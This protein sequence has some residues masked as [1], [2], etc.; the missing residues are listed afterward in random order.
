MNQLALLFFRIRGAMKR[1]WWMPCLMAVLICSLSLSATEGEPSYTEPFRPQY[2]FTP[3]KNWMNDP[4]GLVFYEGEYH[5]FF[6]YN[7]FGDE[8]GHMSWGHAVSTDMVHWKQLPGR[9]YRKENRMIVFQ[10]AWWLTGRIPAAFATASATATTL[11]WL[12]F[13]PDI[14]AASRIKISLIATTVD[15]PG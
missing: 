2:H 6:Q 15:V 12:L 11:V 3:S 10:V 13:T 9:D 14:P 7:P 8:W 5:L 4:N 1:T